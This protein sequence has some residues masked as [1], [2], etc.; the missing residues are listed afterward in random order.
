M[1]KFLNEGL[2]YIEAKQELAGWWLPKIVKR[3]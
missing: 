2:R 3:K 1:G